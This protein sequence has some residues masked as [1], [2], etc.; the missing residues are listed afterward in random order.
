MS[1]RQATAQQVGAAN[2]GEI[3]KRIDQRLDKVEL[4][5]RAA[6]LR[7]GLSAAQL[8]TMRRQYRQGTQHGVSIQT[9]TGL[10]RALE[11][12]PE[13]LMS[14]TGQQETANGIAQTES[15]RGLPFA[16][17]VA[18]GVWNEIGVDGERWAQA[19][20]PPDPRYPVECQSA[21]EVRGTSTDRVARPGDFL[22]VL[23]REKM[24]LPLRSGDLVIMTQTKQG[25]REVTARR[26]KLH[27]GRHLF[28]FELDDPRY[29]MG[30]ELPKIEGN[31]TFQ[32]GGVVVAAYRP[33]A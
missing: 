28:A 1:D 33:L 31:A 11:T 22:I 32:V 8:R 16:G 24:G 5:D 20:A 9:I 21:Y 13:W 12:T 17:V 7:A 30:V 15:A 26:Y 14:G 18:A 2:L 6:S 10:A 29:N 23:D 27:N 4:S 3:L 19:P 25:L